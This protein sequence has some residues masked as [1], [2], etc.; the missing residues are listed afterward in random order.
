MSKPD[1]PLNL[2]IID[3]LDCN[4]C[5]LLY[6]FFGVYNSHSIKIGTGLVKD[7]WFVDFVG[8]ICFSFSPTYSRSI[9]LPAYQY[10]RWLIGM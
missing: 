2:K 1:W 3:Q 5:G 7:D 4:W 10:Y 9:S 8:G 6:Y